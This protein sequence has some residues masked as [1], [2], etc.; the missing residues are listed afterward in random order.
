MKLS[1][2]TKD[3]IEQQS[4]DAFE[5][6]IIDINET[7][8][9]TDHLLPTNYHPL[10]TTVSRSHLSYAK[11]A[12]NATVPIL[13]LNFLDVFED[14]AIGYLLA[15]VDEDTLAASSYITAIQLFIMTIGMTSLCATSAIIGEKFG[16]TIAKQY[17]YR[18]TAE[19]KKEYIANKRFEMGTVLQHSC[20]LNGLI[21]PFLMG[22]LVGIPYLLPILG[23]PSNYTQITQ[24]YFQSY[25][26][27]VPPT[28]LT[29]SIRHFLLSTNDRKFVLGTHLVSLGATMSLGY[30]LSNGAW[31][32]PKLG[33]TGVGLTNVITSWASLIAHILYLSFN[34]KFLSHQLFTRRKETE[35]F[36]KKIFCK[37][38]PVSMQV[39]GEISALFVNTMIIGKL[40]SNPKII[41]SAQN[42][43]SHY[44]TLCIAP[45]ISYCESTAILVSQNR[46]K[47]LFKDMKIFGNTGIALAALTSALIF[48]GVSAAANP[49][50]SFFVAPNNVDREEILALASNLL[51]ITTGTQILDAIRQVA[52]G[53]ALRGILDTTVPMLIGL[54]CLWIIGFP[55][56]LALAFSADL[57]VYGLSIG[58]GVGLAIIAASQVYRW[59][60]KSDEAIKEQRVVEGI[61]I[62]DL[63]NCCKK[64]GNTPSL[65]KV[66]LFASRQ[67]NM[68]KNSQPYTE[69]VYDMKDNQT[70]LRM[71]G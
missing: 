68:I 16:E 17:D 29:S 7:N 70:T 11:E 9:L 46:G 4:K 35:N 5:E 44:L 33:A 31:N 63:F 27:S 60:T 25:I 37:S 8:S 13:L 42:I 58:H 49:L 57:G 2:S 36:L 14:F 28:M 55:T 24:N 10:P 1:L 64:D 26:G 19:E 65:T 62:G 45:M 59:H 43:I 3:T 40:R 15:Q 53:G 30:A 18:A 54:G 34:K 20:G 61:Q 52:S 21:S 39:G 71:S 48:G 51:M 22:G 32:F 12:L 23:Q 67:Q 47:H 69:I 6:K 50:L 38:I 41:L 66:G 56:S